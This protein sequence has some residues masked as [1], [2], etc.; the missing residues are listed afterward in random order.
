[1]PRREISGVLG[2]TTSQITEQ[3]YAKRRPEFLAAAARVGLP[4]DRMGRSGSAT[5][6]RWAAADR[7]SGGVPRAAVGAWWCEVGVP[8]WV[9]VEV[10]GVALRERT[11][12]DRVKVTRVA[13]D[14]VHAPA[15]MPH[16][17]SHDATDLAALNTREPRTGKC[18]EP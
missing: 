18:G 15:C 1:V 7:A 16:E 17:S 6:W 2:H 4:R 5:W 11:A 3:E 8:R 12:I 9:G 10:D 14:E 13:F